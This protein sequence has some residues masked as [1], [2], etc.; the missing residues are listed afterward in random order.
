MSLIHRMNPMGWLLVTAKGWKASMACHPTGSAHAA[1]PW[2]R[3][4]SATQE[5]PRPPLMAQMTTGSCGRKDI[6][7]AQPLWSAFVFNPPSSAHVH[8][9]EV[10]NLALDGTYPPT[11]GDYTVQ[12]GAMQGLRGVRYPLEII[13]N[14]LGGYLEGN[15]GF[16]F[17]VRS[18]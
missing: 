10:V 5:Q 8:T 11:F 7:R 1:M 6:S 12:E 4:A 2:Q 3:V 9:Y 18:E 15:I 13:P 14:D 17:G 16:S